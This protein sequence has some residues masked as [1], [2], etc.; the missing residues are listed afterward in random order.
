MFL[1]SLHFEVFFGALEELGWV[2]FCFLGDRGFEE[3]VMAWLD[4]E[5]DILLE[6]GAV[7]VWDIPDIGEDIGVG[8][9]FLP[10][11]TLG[12]GSF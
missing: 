11:A 3:V 12:G 8:A 7:G 9:C 4:L 1:F 2:N 5:A 10:L 6:G